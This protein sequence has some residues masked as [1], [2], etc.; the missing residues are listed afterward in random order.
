MQLPDL[1]VAGGQ[2]K[3]EAEQKDKWHQ[4]KQGLILR[5]SPQS[6]SAEMHVEYVPHPKLAQR[7]IL[8]L[9]LKLA[10]LRIANYMFV[11]KQRC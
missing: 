2:S 3:K 10:P 6:N 5:V 1:Y 9:Y 7:K 8:R 4:H 11:R